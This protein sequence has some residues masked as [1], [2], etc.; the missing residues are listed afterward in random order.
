MSLS[1]GDLLLLVSHFS[2]YCLT[3]TIG[4]ARGGSSRILD[5]MSASVPGGSNLT[6]DYFWLTMLSMAW[7]SHAAAVGPEQAPSFGVLRNSGRVFRGVDLPDAQALE[8]E[9]FMQLPPCAK[10]LGAIFPRIRCGF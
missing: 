10:L 2:M 9:D 5:T 1:F 3:R 4:R 6:L 7:A 8:F